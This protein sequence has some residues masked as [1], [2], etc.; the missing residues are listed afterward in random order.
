MAA[1]LNLKQ[2]ASHR[3]RMGLSGISHVAVIKAIRDGRL[4]PPAIRKRDGKYWEIDARLADQQ[5]SANSASPLSDEEEN[6]DQA[7]RTEP[8]ASHGAAPETDGGMP[9]V[10]SLA[11]SRALKA[12][13]EVRIARL[14]LMEL[15]GFYVKKEDVLRD[16]VRIGQETRDMVTAMADRL[17]PA[18][19]S[20]SDIAQCHSILMDEV[21]SVLGRLSRSLEKV[22]RP[23]T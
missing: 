2:Y 11:S 19:A 23:S 8:M 1:P 22:K 6:T 18:L 4:T 9:K 15:E 16:A 20:E 7:R 17:A 10:P 5:W 12:A 3:R 21:R 13:Y 14:E